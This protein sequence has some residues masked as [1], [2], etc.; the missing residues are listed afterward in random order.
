MEDH[1]TARD[2]VVDALVALDVALHQIDVSLEMEE[3][4]SPS[5][6]EVIQD[7]NVMAIMEERLGDVGS[8]E[9][10]ATGHENTH[11]QI[12]PSTEWITL[13]LG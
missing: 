3:V 6:G 12:L 13:G 11:V 10:A 1:V 2:R 7:A 4:L 9:P 8:D 5:R